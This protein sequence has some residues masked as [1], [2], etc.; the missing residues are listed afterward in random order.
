MKKFII[1][2]AFAL[3]TSVFS[4]GQFALGLKIGYNGSKLTTDLDSI[5]NQ[6]NSG[7]HVGA[8]AHFGKRFYVAPEVLYCMSGG[9]FSY[10]GAVSSPRY[11]SQKITVGSLDIPVMLGFKIIHSD[12]ITWRVEL[13]PEASFAMHKK[14]SEDINPKIQPADINT[15]NWYVLGGTGIDFLF[16]TFD[17]RYKYGLS[18]L[19]KDA[20]NQSF[21]T[22]NNVF[23]VSL[24]FKIFG[25][26]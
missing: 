3:T 23:L 7:F 26:K 24:G 15:A 8:Y 1:L 22:K 10:D 21:D 11:W 4:Y 17:V 16:L 20:S 18:K 6:F 9:V 13:G 2:L 25:K 12:F 14:V 19:I 5:K